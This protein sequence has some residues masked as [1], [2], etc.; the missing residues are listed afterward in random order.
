MRPIPKSFGNFTTMRITIEVYNCTLYNELSRA[1]IE[2]LDV[3]AKGQIVKYNK[4]LPL[5]QSI[6]LSSNHL[7]GEI[8]EELTSFARIGLLEFVKKPFKWSYSEKIARLKQLQSLVLSNNQL[9]WVIPLS[10]SSLTSLSV[11]SLSNNNLSGPIPTGN[12]METFNPSIYSGN[13]Y[14]CLPSPTQGSKGKPEPPPSANRIERSRKRF[15]FPWLD[16]SIGLGFG[17]GFEGTILLLF[18]RKS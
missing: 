14:L 12:Q 4:I 15:E 17:V 18:I 11:L 10:I 9:T 5:V 7:E 3:E 16:M 2:R 1:K 6:D 8:P 13:P